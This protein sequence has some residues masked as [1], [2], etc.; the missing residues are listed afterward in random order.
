MILRFKKAEEE[1]A[2]D[3]CSEADRGKLENP[4]VAVSI[5]PSALPGINS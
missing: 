3:S 5:L 2:I 4:R 1:V